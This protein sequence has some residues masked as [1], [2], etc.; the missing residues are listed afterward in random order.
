MLR[1]SSIDANLQTE[2]R[3][4]AA[5]LTPTRILVGMVLLYFVFLTA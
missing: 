3:S 2:R 4:L 5:L 1:S